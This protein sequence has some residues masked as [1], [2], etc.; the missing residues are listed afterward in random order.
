[1]ITDSS[2]ITFLPLY[3]GF[4]KWLVID[5]IFPLRFVL[6]VLRLVVRKVTATLEDVIVIATDS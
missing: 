2:S 1:M 6:L 4:S 3:V 5:Q